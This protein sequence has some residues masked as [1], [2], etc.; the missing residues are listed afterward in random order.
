M[1]KYFKTISLKN[2][3]IIEFLRKRGKQNLIIVEA[4]SEEQQIRKKEYAIDNDNSTFWVSKPN[5]GY[6][7]YLSI[8]IPNIKMLVTGYMLYYPESCI[9]KQWE[10]QTSLDKSNWT[11]ADSQSTSIMSNHEYNKFKTGPTIAKYFR[12]VHKGPNG[13]PTIPD[14]RFHIAELDIYGSLLDYFLCSYKI[15]LNINLSFL[16]IIII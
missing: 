11:I 12:F 3:G 9:P 6:N 16:T 2:V 4:D 1:N 8:E 5:N 10:F 15:K 13:C 14:S 7:Q